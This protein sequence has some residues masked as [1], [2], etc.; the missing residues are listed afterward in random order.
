MREDGLGW[1]GDG[2]IGGLEYVPNWLLS[3][4]EVRTTTLLLLYY[5]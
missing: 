3:I 4:E 1:I 2:M 5:Y